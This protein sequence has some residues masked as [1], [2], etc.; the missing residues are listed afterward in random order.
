[1]YMT[2][3]SQKTRDA[4]RGSPR[5]PAAQKTLAQDDNQPGTLLSTPRIDRFPQRTL[6]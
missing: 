2:I 3:A 5:S 4:S 1:M 6:E